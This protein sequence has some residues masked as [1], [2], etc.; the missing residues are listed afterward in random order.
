MKRKELN[1]LFK[2]F[3]INDYQNKF[4]VVIETVIG[5]L[6][7]ENKRDHEMVKYAKMKKDYF[8]NIR[9]IQYYT[10]NEGRNQIKENSKNN[11]T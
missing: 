8:D 9:Y 1:R 11:N 7:G 3:F 2:E 4:H 5:A 10:L 6:V